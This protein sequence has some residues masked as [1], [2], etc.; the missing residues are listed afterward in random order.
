MG[1]DIMHP[2]LAPLQSG[3]ARI[4]IIAAKPPRLGE[5]CGSAF[6][7]AFEGIGRSQPEVRPRKSRIGA[8]RLFDPK[9]RL[10]GT[11]LQQMNHANP[12]IPIDDARITRAEADGLF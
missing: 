8:P 11:R 2:S 7:F 3:H 1:A 12:P 4:T 10:S 6:S 9:D 5:L